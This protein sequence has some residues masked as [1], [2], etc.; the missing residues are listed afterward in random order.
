[1]LFCRSFL[2]A[3]LTLRDGLRREDVVYAS[4][5]SAYPS[6]RGA[7]LGNALGYHMPHLTVLELGE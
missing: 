1:M 2:V 3:P 7:R 6:A 5:P 4:L